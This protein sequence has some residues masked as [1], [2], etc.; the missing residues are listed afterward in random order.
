MSDPATINQLATTINGVLKDLITGGGASVVEASLITQYPFLGLPI[1][2]QLFEWV[3]GLVAGDIYEQ[4]AMAATK[5][6]I[7]VQVDLE[8]SKTSDAFKSL[9]MA[10]ASGDPGAIQK[11]SSDLN[12]AY[13][14]LIH[15][16][17]SASP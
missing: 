7:D 9:Q 14:S 12:D 6:V 13:S 3:V 1:I 11:A 4:A 5:I 17:G 2:R 8:V 16:D 10:I 15:S